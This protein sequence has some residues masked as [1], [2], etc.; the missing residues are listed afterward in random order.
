MRN[1]PVA[2]IL[3]T[4]LIGCDGPKQS[5]DSDVPV[6][7][8]VESGVADSGTDS[9]P[10]ST[11]DSAGPV[12][13]DSDGY[14]ST[15]SGGTDCDDTNAAVNPGA[16]EVCD[17]LDDN[18]DG[19]I[20]EG[21]QSTYYAD[22]DG[23]GYG[24]GAA[25]QACP[26]ADGSPPAG[27]S[28]SSDDC[29]DDASGVHPGAPET[30]CTDATD[31]NCDGSTGY[32]DADGDGVPACQDCNDA[33]ASS[34][35]GAVEVCDGADNN[36][37]GTV[38]EGV[39]ST[40]YADVDGDGYGD[41]A[42]STSDCAAPAGFVA[43]S[44]DCD[45]DPAAGGAAVNP[46]AT[47]TCDGVDDNCDGEVDEG[48]TTTFYLDA[49]ADGYGDD[50]LTAD[51]CDAPIG[52]AATG[53]DCDDTDPSVHPYATESCSDP[54]DRNCDGSVGYADADGDGSAACLDCNDGNALVYPGAPEACDGLDNNCDGTIDE[55]VLSTFYA[56]SDGDGY[57]D[58]AV[59]SEAC[60]ATAGYVSDATDCDDTLA[61]VN[62]GAVE[63]CD[64]L[65]D[66]CDGSVDEGVLSTFYADADRDGYGD[67]SETVLACSPSAGFVADNTDC[68]DGLAF[69]HPGAPEFCDGIDEDCDGVA[70]NGVLITWYLDADS[71]GYGVAT[72]TIDACSQPA[73]YAA[74]S[75][76]CDDANALYHPGAAEA[77]CTDPN[78]YN[79]DGSTAYTDA[80]SDGSPA[81]LDC[82]DADPAVHPG[83][84]EVCNG[85]DD[86]CD[87]TID[88]DGTADGLTF[89]FD[90]DRD[91]YGD[92]A[93]PYVACAL[94]DGFVVDATDCDDS[95]ASIHPGAPEV[96]DGVD[97]DCNG[98]AD[99]GA[100]DGTDWYPDGDTD[101]YG[102]GTPVNACSAPVGYVATNDDCRDDNAAI[103][104]EADG[105][106]A[107]GSSCLDILDAGL[108]TGS[109]TYTIDA[110]GSR[111]GTA[112]FSIACEM[113]IDGGGWTQALASYL[114]TL[115]TADTH[116]YLYTYGAAWY[117]SPAS[118]DV[119][120]WDGYQGLGGT[121]LYSSG[122]TSAEGS[123]GCTPNEGGYWG[124]GCSNGGGRQYK[125]LPIY[126]DDPSEA[127]SMICEDLPDV[128]GAGA[129]RNGVSIWVR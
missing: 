70:D 13:A 80:D 21:L 117:E 8:S 33:S 11:P 107:D 74:S 108:S 52:Y 91:G 53:G 121:Y 85:F 31:Y 9:T 28:A 35:P 92:A 127:T 114:D 14:P 12:D 89:Y 83:A 90:S 45:D 82:N 86:D 118:N 37:D 120:S 5:F 78:D 104:P 25:T 94:P 29:N 115:S 47:E 20:D 88:N 125:V 98:I 41:P 50:A 105:T 106:C 17:G 23:D 46:G 67:A 39:Q 93:S 1:F 101:G 57:G 113:T 18:C 30:D 87:G 75:D 109:G 73:G 79:C 27:Y 60:A 65:D 122:S 96:C 64:G 123:F 2:L 24:A 48:V 66:N 22:A 6:Q 76:D 97:Q 26:A 68:S 55:G 54:V 112:P 77:D 119:W 43:D 110:D 34:S 63:V 51:A 126:T 56:D 49:D 84:V 100:V 124:V 15:S 3:P 7:D 116:T 4:L 59:T 128:F 103:F 61:S 42:R 58:A 111:T 99:D 36:C 16:A 129:C 95:V 72:S 102:A 69:V 71:D 32:A 40:F 38:D 19:R 81:C 62:P 44:S 10:D